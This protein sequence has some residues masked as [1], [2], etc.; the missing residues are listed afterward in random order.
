MNRYL[1]EKEAT[2]GTINQVEINK[3]LLGHHNK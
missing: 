1:L 3:C 2:I